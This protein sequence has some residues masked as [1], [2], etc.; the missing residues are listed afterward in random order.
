MLNILQGVYI[1][2]IFVCKRDVLNV[3]FKKGTI[4]NQLDSTKDDSISSQYRTENVEMDSIDYVQRV[5]YLTI[6]YKRYL[7]NLYFFLQLRMY[8]DMFL[9]MIVI[10]G[11]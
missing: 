8:H 9:I 2:I 3:I 6:S 4:S 11:R 10:T 7:L 1:F 5:R